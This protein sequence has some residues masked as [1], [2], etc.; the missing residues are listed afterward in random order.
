MLHRERRRFFSENINLLLLVSVTMMIVTMSACKHAKQEEQAVMTGPGVQLTEEAMPDT[1]KSLLEQAVDWGNENLFETQRDYEEFELQDKSYQGK[2]YHFMFVQGGDSWS[3][4]LYYVLLNEQGRFQAVIP[5]GG[6]NQPLFSYDIVSL[7]GENYVAVYCASHMGNGDLE[8]YSL[9]Q[10]DGKPYIIENVI[11][12]H[13]EAMALVNEYGFPYSKS[14]IY[15]DGK[16]NAEFKD[17]DQDGYTDIELIGMKLQYER[18][19]S[20]E[21]EKLTNSLNYKRAYLYDSSKQLF[22]LYKEEEESIYTEGGTYYDYTGYMDIHPIFAQGNPRADYDE[23][24]LLDRVFKKYDS[25]TNTSSF[26]L[27][28]GNGT[29]LLLSDREM[30]YFFQTEAAD[31]TGDGVKEIMFEQFS[32]ST[33]CS[34]LYLTIYTFKSGGY[35]KMDIPFYSDPVNG[36][37]DDMLYLPLVMKKIDD[38]SVSIYQPDCNYHGIIKTQSHAYDSGE[39]ADEMEHLYFPETEGVEVLYQGSTME[40]IDTEDAEKNAILLH[41]YLGDKWCIKSVFWTLEYLQ[42]EWRI[43]NLSQPDPILIDLGTE[44]NADL[45]GDWIEDTIYYNIE[46]RQDN[47]FDYEMP[48]LKVNGTE[49]D[50]KY[51]EENFGVYLSTCSHIGYYMI[52]LDASDH[53]REIAILDEGPSDDPVTH[54]FRYDNEELIYCG[55]VTDFP[56][57]FRFFSNGRGAVTARKRLSILQTWYASADWRL[58]ESGFLEEQEADRYYPYQYETEESRTNYAREDLILFR[59]PDKGSDVVTIKKG[60]KLQLTATDNKNWVEITTE[61]GTIGWFYLHDGYEVTL[62]TGE[63]KIGDILTYLN[64][65]D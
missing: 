26:Y 47:G 19:P 37:Q 44:F 32:M 12:H 49:Y 52:D 25:N 63:Y 20:D 59:L 4:E 11:D 9:E 64:M 29:N 46:M 31:L 48:L 45:N 42:G 60:E 15:Y 61:G 7:S 56:S 57:N 5:C 40:L 50:Y 28:F 41:S 55:N 35:E 13:Y 6:G 16:L 33:K 43:T 30:G 58:N 17:I 21:S 51:L 8:L 24:G 1:D 54:F 2:E 10:E 62:P 65:A 36:E 27:H 22:A 23:D 39:I 14:Q 34:N 3:C 53:Y 38:T 18:Y